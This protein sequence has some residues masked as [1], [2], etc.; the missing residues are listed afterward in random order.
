MNFYK[1]HIGDYDQAT[2][3]LSFVEDAAYSRLIRKYYAEERPLPA[4]IKQVQRLIG[5]RTRDEKEA[6]ET[7]LNEFFT[8]EDDGWHNKRCDEEIAQANKQAE[9]NRRIA[10]EREAKKRARM[11]NESSTNRGRKGSTNRDAAEHE[12]WSDGEAS[13]IGNPTDFDAASIGSAENFSGGTASRLP[14]NPRQSSKSQHES[15]SSREPSQ[16]PDSR[17]QTPDIEAQQ[18]NYRGQSRAA[19]GAND[20]AVDVAVLLRSLGVSPMT[21]QHPAAREFADTGATDD[22]LRAAV[23]IA[24]E[25]KPAPEPISPNYLRPI[26]GEIL[27][28]PAP[29]PAKPKAVPLIAMT[30]AQLN[31]AG[32]A[33]GVGE[34]RIGE[35]RHEYIARIQ[36][37]QA[38]AQGRAIA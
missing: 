14:G 1:H 30:D 4:E 9:T 19:E 17:L 20:R 33:A 36:T 29:R 26:L 2:R 12:S 6:V 18:H 32:V 15:W 16:T 3:H 37:A 7:V 22:Q 23:D 34:A 25:R 38:I 10:L 28:P 27:N 13:P 8:L 5:A 35:T 21:G 31:A 11:A 24:R